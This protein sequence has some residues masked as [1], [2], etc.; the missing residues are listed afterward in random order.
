MIVAASNLTL[1]RKKKKSAGKSVMEERVPVIPLFT[2]P[3]R[4]LPCATLSSGIP[5]SSLS[6]I[7]RCIKGVSLSSA[8]KDPFGS[9]EIKG[10]NTIFHFKQ[11]AFFQNVYIDPGTTH[12]HTKKKL[13]LDGDTKHKRSKKK[14]KKKHGRLMLIINT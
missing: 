8:K 2:D 14:K 6:R 5:M 7:S 12:T 3:H 10:I 4:L 13:L 9:Y 1:K 11:V